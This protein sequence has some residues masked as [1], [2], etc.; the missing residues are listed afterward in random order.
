MNRNAC[1]YNVNVF[2]VMKSRRFI[3]GV[4]KSRPT[5]GMQGGGLLHL[6]PSSAFDVPNLFAFLM[7]RLR[8][9][10]N[11]LLIHR[12]VLERQR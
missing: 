2:P 5:S 8:Q 1:Q 9:M 4:F 6:E 10:A 11:L 12:F 3:S 7:W